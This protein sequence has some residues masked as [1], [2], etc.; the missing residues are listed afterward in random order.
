TGLDLCAQITNPNVKKVLLTGVADERLAIEALNIELIDF[1]ISKRESGLAQRLRSIIAHLETR[2][3][4][5]LYA[6]SRDSE[7]RNIL[8]QL[9]DAAF[10][11]YFEDVIERLNIVEY[12]PLPD[13]RGFRLIDGYGQC[14]RLVVLNEAQLNGLLHNADLSRLSAANRDKLQQRGLIPT[15][16]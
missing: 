13:S 15:V 16:G 9:F 12:Y 1:Y 7:V 10:A 6:W 2:Y 3:F 8:P 4:Q 14:K 5:D 11:D